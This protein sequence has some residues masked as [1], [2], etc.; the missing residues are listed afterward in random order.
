MT[1]P[2]VKDTSKRTKIFD[3]QV[4]IR[5]G[6][7]PGAING[8]LFWVPESSA[9]PPGDRRLR[10]SCLLGLPFV[11]VGAGAGANPPAAATPRPARE[12]EAW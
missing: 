4:P 8:E 11:L 12:R 9:A 3:W 10:R 6:D 2:Q 1:P 7:T 5:V